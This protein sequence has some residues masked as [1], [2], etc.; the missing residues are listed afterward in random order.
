MALVECRECKQMV[1]DSAETC[2]YCGV[3]RPGFR[4]SETAW[5]LVI[6]ALALPVLAIMGAVCGVF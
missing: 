3:G 2:P 1:S 6:M 4:W 5:S